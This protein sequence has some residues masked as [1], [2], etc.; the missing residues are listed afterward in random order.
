MTKRVKKFNDHSFQLELTQ[1]QKQLNAYIEMLK[2]IKKIEPDAKNLKELNTLLNKRT[3]FEN[4]QM[5]ATAFNLESEYDS[6]VLL[7]QKCKGISPEEVTEDF[8]LTKEAVQQIKEKHTTYY[9]D[10]ELEARKVLDRVIEQYNKLP[11]NQRRLIGFNYKF[12]LQYSPLA[13]RL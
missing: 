6:I 8:K 9:D 11:L 7:Q 12:Q 2:K 13:S 4:P 5:S 3:K 10:S 1:K